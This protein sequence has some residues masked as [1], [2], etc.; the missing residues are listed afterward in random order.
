MLTIPVASFFTLVCP[1]ELIYLLERK[2]KWAVQP[3]DTTEALGAK[4][5]RA[6]GR[7]EGLTEVVPLPAL[8]AW[9]S[10]GNRLREDLH[11]GV[12]PEFMFP[13][14]GLT[15]WP[16][17]RSEM[18]PFPDHLLHVTSMSGHEQT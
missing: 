15:R 17:I 9:C 3:S 1:P 18:L 12:G 8:I 11:L 2:R 13:L 16:V 5:P 6:S 7:P 10:F 14:A 4:A